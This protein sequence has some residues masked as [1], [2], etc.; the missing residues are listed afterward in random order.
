MR[1]LNA[2]IG[3]RPDSVNAT[4]RGSGRRSGMSLLEV[5]VTL[6]LAGTLAALIGEVF[7]QFSRIRT[8]GDESSRVITAVPEVF[9]LINS[10]LQTLASLDSSTQESST[11]GISGNTSPADK[12]AADRFFLSGNATELMMA[13]ESSSGIPELHSFSSGEVSAEDS[14][15]AL[16]L[17]RGAAVS[18]KVVSGACHLVTVMGWK[19][20]SSIV[21]RESETVRISALFHRSARMRFEYFDGRQWC[22]EWNSEIRERLPSLIRVTVSPLDQMTGHQFF[23]PV[24]SSLRLAP[25]LLRR[26]EKSVQGKDSMSGPAAPTT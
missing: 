21:N 22:N 18:G 16:K 8:G 25:S 9:T 13:V 15:E 23:L 2:V 10:S 3:I 14:I 24:S 7:L 4:R 1:R 19:P 6:A 11:G 17:T 20:G 26:S 5:L 12:N